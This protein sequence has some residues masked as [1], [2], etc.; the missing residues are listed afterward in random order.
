M[1]DIN[2]SEHYKYNNSTDGLVD[3]SEHT[4]TCQV[5]FLTNLSNG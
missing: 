3:I 5:T 4:Y 2:V 1:V